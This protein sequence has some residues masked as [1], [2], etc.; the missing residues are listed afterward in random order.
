MTQHMIYLSD[1][2]TDEIN[3]ILQLAA[4]VKQYPGRYSG[5]LSGKTLAMLF[6]KPST[7]TRISFTQAMV[8]TGGFPLYL[9]ASD[10]QLGRGETIADTAKVLSRYVQ[11]IMARTFAHST[12]EELARFATI[13]VI[14]GLTDQYHPCQA[15]ADAQTIQERFGTLKGLTLA[16]V[17]DGNNV[18][19]SL[20]MVGAKTGMNVVVI[21]PDNF[22]PDPHVVRIAKEAA[23]ETGAVISVTS[24]LQAVRGANVVYT[25]TW[26]SM[27]Q[28]TEREARLKVFTP[29]QVNRD[30]MAMADP[31]AIFLHCL[32]C[33]RGEEVSAEVID[34]PQSAIFDEAENRLHAQK[35]VLVHLLS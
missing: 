14:N 19:H 27:G 25:D 35:A 18:A 21:S 26:V 1:W 9:S 13:P 29:Y 23:Q 7:R 30:V 4:T 32:P 16:Y 2:S 8:Q 28:D 11:A 17:G 24:D 34:G 20:M 33:H 6:E 5:A 10:L 12:V 22:Q 15:L 3:H 31:K